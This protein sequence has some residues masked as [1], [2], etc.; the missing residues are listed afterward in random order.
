[1]LWRSAG[2]LRVSCKANLR[3]AHYSLWIDFT[4]LCRPVEK[5]KVIKSS[6]NKDNLRDFISKAS[7]QGS[8]VTKFIKVQ[9]HSSSMT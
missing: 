5:W 7:L 9:L 2:V 4:G 6:A 1:M 3:S 8:S